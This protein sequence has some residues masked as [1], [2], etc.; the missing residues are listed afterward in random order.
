MKNVILILLLTFIVA[1][2][3]YSKPIN[4]DLN[5]AKM[6]NVT[7]EILY[8]FTNPDQDKLRDYISKSW[9]KKEGLNIKYYIINSY[10]P[11]D[12][13][14]LWST[15]NIV[16]V[17]IGGEEWKHLLIFKFIDEDGVYRMIP[18]GLSMG[19]NDYIDPWWD[20]REYVCREKDDLIEEKPNFDK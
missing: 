15:S 7:S 12:Y 18:K 17:E 5:S 14:I 11:D 19:G 6:T 3:S 2:V 20:V 4:D 13:V 10:Y 16:V 1:A 9:L 8:L